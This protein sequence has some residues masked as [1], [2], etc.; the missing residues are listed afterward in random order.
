MRR[1]PE[2][3]STSLHCLTGVFDEGGYPGRGSGRSRDKSGLLAANL[4]IH[5]VHE[6]AN[7]PADVF[8]RIHFSCSVRRRQPP[9]Y[10]GAVYLRLIQIN[11]ME[12]DA[13]MQVV[14]NAVSTTLGDGACSRLAARFGG[15]SYCGP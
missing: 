9:L 12:S 14:R 3:Q 13:A 2:V 4:I 7:D 5:P 15:S 1:G 10:H 11:E 6:P 8:A